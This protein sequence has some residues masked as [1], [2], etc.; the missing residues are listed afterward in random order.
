MS[1]ATEGIGVQIEAKANM[2]VFTV[3]V[4]SPG[5]IQLSMERYREAVRQG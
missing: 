3:S 2:C 4:L 5:P 1:W